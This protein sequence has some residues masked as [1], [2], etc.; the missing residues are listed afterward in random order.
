ML[1]LSQVLPYPLDAGAKVRAYYILRWLAD[2][3]DVTLVS[4][5]R[6][7]DS[8]EAVTHL[9]EFCADL[10]TVP[11]H[12]SQLADCWH[13]ARA[14]ATGRSFIVLRDERRSMR[15]VLVDLCRR[16]EFDAVHADQISVA[17]Y[18]LQL[19]I[20]FCVLD[21]HN[22]VYRVCESLASGESSMLRRRLLVRE[23]CKVARYEAEQAASFSR[24]LFVSEVDRQA[25]CNVAHPEERAL[26]KSGSRVLPICIDC[27]GF[28]RVHSRQDARRITVIG[29]MFWPPNSQGVLWFAEHVLPRILDECPDAVLTVVGK[30]PP[31]EVRALERRFAGSV[32]V[33]GY[34]LDV[35]PLLQ[36]TAAL[37]VPL[38]SGGGMRV[39]ILDAWRWGL[40][41]VSSRVGAEGIEVQDGIDIVLAD[42]PEAFARALVVLLQQPNERERIGAA[43]R[44]AVEESYDAGRGYSGLHELYAPVLVN[45]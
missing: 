43:G 16:R 44:A 45:E 18:A 13:L 30:R 35:L 36:E 9:R 38:L 15:R 19:S 24:T 42:T 7:D 12:R 32:E 28:E 17:G 31:S 27:T 21:Y 11:M 2:W 3:A 39:K 6:T 41:V 14:L 22:A 33:T 1:F 5:V 29:T 26:I 34:V 20:P 10:V 23:A 8:P 4:F 40:P 25:I 37:I